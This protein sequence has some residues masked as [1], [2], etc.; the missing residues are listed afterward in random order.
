MKN[1][2]LFLFVLSLSLSFSLNAQNGWRAGEK[3]V[4]VIIENQ[5]QSQQLHDLHL[6]GD[7][8]SD[9]AI[10]YVIPVEYDRLI[11]SGFTCEVLINDLNKHYKNFWKNKDAYHSYQEIIDLRDSLVTAFPSIC[12]KTI[13]GTSV[14]GREL[15][16][17]KISDNVLTDENEAE[18]M[19]DG[20]IHGDEIG[21]AENC[22]RFAKM[23]CLEYGNDP[24]I[25]DL[26]DTR[27]IWIYL[28]VN[29]DG[30][31]NMSRYNANGVDLNR[32]WGY[33]WDAWGNSTGAY[34][35]VES[36]ALRA[37][38]S[39]NQFVVHTT[40]HSGTEYVSYPWSYRS[41]WAPDKAHIDYLSISPVW[42]LGFLLLR[43]VTFPFAL[44]TN[45]RPSFLALSQR[46]APVSILK[47]NCVIP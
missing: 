38:M 1:F 10:L 32:D 35:Q 33:M 2:I 4:K 21:A 23:L 27:E 34:S 16:A 28:M 29:P 26:I 31:E 30:R 43:S 6:N 45:S 36:K 42:R 46:A 22:I 19:F 12:T 25:T 11:N 3:E 20:G 44:I 37:C 47:T 40:Y 17:M 14:E 24:T 39:E 9:H 15:T 18:V 13:Y 41:S 7:F 8:Y 5:S